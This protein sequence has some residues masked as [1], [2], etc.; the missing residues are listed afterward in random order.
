MTFSSVIYYFVPLCIY[1][2]FQLAF[3]FKQQRHQTSDK[4][5]KKNTL[6]K[7]NINIAP[8]FLTLFYII[9]FILTFYVFICLWLQN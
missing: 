5:Q 6:S 8:L 1:E 7:V 3:F 9:S 4:M 2:I